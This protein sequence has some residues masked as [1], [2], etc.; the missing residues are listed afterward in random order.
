MGTKMSDLMTLTLKYDLVLNSFNLCHILLTGSGKAFIFH[1][2]MQILC[3][4]LSLRTMICD[5]F[6]LTLK[7]D[8]LLKNFNL[9]DSFLT[10][11]GG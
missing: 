5:F 1:I 2:Y 9:D 7:F 4:D 10:R 11:R 3:L 6:T 8:L